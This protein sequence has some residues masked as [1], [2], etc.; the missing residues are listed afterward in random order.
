VNIADA[1]SVLAGLFGGGPPP[2]APYPDCGPDGTADALPACAY[3][4]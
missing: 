2:P 3:P 1:V 4:C